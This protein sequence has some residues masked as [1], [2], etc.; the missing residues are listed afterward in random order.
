MA[1]M[2]TMTWRRGSRWASA[3]CDTTLGDMRTLLHAAAIC[4]GP[5]QSTRG[6]PGKRHKIEHKRLLTAWRLL[7][8]TRKRT[9]VHRAD[10]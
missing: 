5:P 3:M 7:A 2:V 4:R 6:R 1:R 9:D 8:G 10:V